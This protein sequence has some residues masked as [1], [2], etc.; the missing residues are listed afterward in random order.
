M[1]ALGHSLQG[2]NKTRK[3]TQMNSDLWICADFLVGLETGLLK[4][5]LLTGLLSPR[6][7]LSGPLWT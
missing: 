7:E 3:L 4:I 6:R 1:S 5:L 2:N